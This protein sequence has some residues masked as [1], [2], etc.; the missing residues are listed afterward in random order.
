MKLSLTLV[1]LEVIK[2]VTAVRLVYKCSTTHED[3]EL[4]ELSLPLRLLT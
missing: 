4:T 1:G 3:T 2:N